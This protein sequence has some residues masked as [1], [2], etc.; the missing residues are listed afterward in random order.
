MNNQSELSSLFGIIAA[1]GIIFLAILLG[2]GR[3]ENFIDPP[4]LLIIFG[5]TFFVSAASFSFSEVFHAGSVVMKTIFYSRED[6]RQVALS[7]IKT[8][9]VA[10]KQGTLKL[11]Q[12]EDLFKSNKFFETGMMMVIDGMTSKEIEKIMQQEINSTILRHKNGVDILRKSSE[13]APAMGLIGTLIGLV[14]MLGNLEDPSK[15]G[16]AMAVAL[17][18]TLYGALFSYVILTPLASKLERNSKNEVMIMKIYMDT[19]SSIA[20][21][22]TPRKLEMLINSDLPPK[23]RVSYFG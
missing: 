10:K 19:V 1:L 13:V 20:K 3:V 12:K 14:Q 17:L 9:E 7:C 23:L 4:S 15:I 16:P 21:R 18:T 8:A 11:E 2:N 22:E 5:G 6:A